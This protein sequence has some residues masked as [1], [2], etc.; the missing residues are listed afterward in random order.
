MPQV[1]TLP[2]PAETRQSFS[3]PPSS[4]R[5]ETSHAGALRSL[6]SPILLMNALRAH[7][8]NAPLASLRLTLEPL[9]SAH[10]PLLFEALQDPELYAWISTPPPAS[11]DALT[12]RWRRHESRLSPRGDEAWLNWIVRER[13]GAAIGKCDV[14]VDDQNVATNVG[15]ILLRPFW[16]R[17][18]TT[19]AVQ[20]VAGHLESLSVG[21]LRALVTSGNV[22][23]ARVLEKAGFVRTR[24]L[25]AND[26][27]RGVPHD[28]IEF[29][30]GRPS[31][32]TGPASIP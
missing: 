1:L 21:P 23:S 25:P 27:I 24:V 5:L 11:L 15:Y 30:R 29:V 22:A 14:V 32:F 7:A 26:T 17:G 28:D 20:L 12:Q 4:T 3:L 2:F 19:E 6:R 18:Y 16:N 10:A 9:T 13:G 31:N 8:L